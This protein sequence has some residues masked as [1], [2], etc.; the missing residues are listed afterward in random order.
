MNIEILVVALVTLA[1]WH[2][3]RTHR[4]RVEKTRLRVNGL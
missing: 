2:R 1:M 3:R 4:R